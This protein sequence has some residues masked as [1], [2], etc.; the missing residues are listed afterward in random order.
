MAKLVPVEPFDIVVFG[1]TGDLALRKLIPALFHRWCDGQITDDSRIICASRDA[2]E[3]SAFQELAATHVITAA[4]S[5]ERKA[6]WAGFAGRLRYVS[7]DAS[8]ETTGWQDLAD[9][10][11]PDESKIRLYYLALPP[12][13]YG[14]I[15]A[16]LAAHKLN[17]PNARIVLEKPI[18]S[19]Y[20][21]ARAINDRVGEVFLENNIFRIDHYLGKETVQNLLILR[22]ANYLFEPLWNANGI[23][24]VQI[25]VAESLGAGKRAS[26]YDRSGA[27]RDM[28]QNHLLQLACLVAMEPPASLDPD[29]VRTEKLKVLKALRPITAANVT[30]DV[31]RGQYQAGA[32]NG[33][34]V[35]GYADEV[36]HA[37]QTETF[38]GVRAHVD[39]WRWA[40]VP[41][42]LRTGK[43]M[44][45]RRSEIIVQ[46]KPIPHDVV[47]ATAG[48][49]R[50]NRLVIRLQ[51]DEGVKLMLMTKDPGPGGLRLRYVPLNLAYAEH[52]DHDYPDA[53]E[54]LLMAVVRGNLS[55]FMRR[56]EV[57]AAWRWVDGIIQSWDD[58]QSRLYSYQAGTDGPPQSALLL[59]R[60]DREWFDGA[61]E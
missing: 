52:F 59:A 60:E 31:V 21:T 7:V 40:G 4:T 16:G 18:G 17:T 56:D 54:R 33:G 49:M 46:F 47:G 8:S 28:V 25:T 41:F 13:I 48:T 27:L 39:N 10:L 1:A 26:Y 14:S 23:D 36:G 20:H 11:D 61:D 2:M 19:N 30:Q 9:A 57:E 43:R 29:A 3:S 42:Y 6:S 37:T 5:A 51:P 44:A 12:S 24:H 34:T 50:P 55:L 38:V 35:P 32:V 45:A 22:F 53:Y 15:C 58:S